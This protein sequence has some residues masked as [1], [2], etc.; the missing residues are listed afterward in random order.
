MKTTI[1]YF[2]S[3]AILLKWIKRTT[4]LRI[5]SS[6][7]TRKKNSIFWLFVSRVA[8][9]A[10]ASTRFSLI[11]QF[12]YFIPLS[13]QLVLFIFARIG[14]GHS[15]RL[16]SIAHFH[17]VL[18]RRFWQRLSIAHIIS[19]ILAII[20]VPPIHRSLLTAQIHFAKIC[21]FVRVNIN[22]FLCR[23]SNV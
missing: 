19:I 4:I 5:K 18:K 12:W 21:L 2:K 7:F 15:T 13:I 10:A 8:S 23:C 14:T 3:K 20:K 16:A 17:P 22:V 9:S 6:I 11:Y 1:F